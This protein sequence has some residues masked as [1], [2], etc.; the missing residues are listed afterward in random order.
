MLAGEASVQSVKSLPDQALHFFVSFRK[1][2]H[3]YPALSYSPSGKPCARSLFS[4]EVDRFQRRPCQKCQR[5]GSARLPREMGYHELT[6]A[7]VAG[8]SLRGSLRGL[9]DSSLFSPACCPTLIV[10]QEPYLSVY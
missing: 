2:F 4:R 1:Q 8:G 5:L 9:M 10:G 6:G 7:D 3:L